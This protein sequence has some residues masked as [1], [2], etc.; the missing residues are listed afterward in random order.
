M[1]R[2]LTRTGLL[3][4]LALSLAGCEDG[5]GIGPEGTQTQVRL[6]QGSVAS[7]SLASQ[8][9]ASFNLAAAA[10]GAGG[11]GG[12]GPVALS[13]VASLKLAVTEVRAVPVQA[14][15]ARKGEWV[16]LKVVNPTTLDLLTLPTSAENGVVLAS[17]D[18]P[19]GSYQ[20]L[21]IFVQNPVIVFKQDVRVGPFTYKAGQEHPVNIP[22]ADQT[23]IKV[24]TGSFAIDEAGAEVRV[25]F[26][27]AASLGKIIPAGPTGIRM[28]PVIGGKADRN[29][30]DED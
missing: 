26:D 17:G 30:R 2:H 21:R 20:N 9:V 22:G 15:T 24:P 29:D 19:A 25:V 12:G 13:N 11:Q 14:D 28:T 3:A 1:I 23:G 8:A 5:L 27:P 6:S 18:L 10:P 4:G 16:T 7:Q